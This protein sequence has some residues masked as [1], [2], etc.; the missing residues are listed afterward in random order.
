M[1]RHKMTE[2]QVR[3]EVPAKIMAG[4]LPEVVVVAGL[5]RCVVRRLRESRWIVCVEMGK[6]NH[7]G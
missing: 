4:S 1:S 3:G 6:S 2:Q 5:R 7:R